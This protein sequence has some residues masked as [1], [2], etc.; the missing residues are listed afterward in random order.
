MAGF[1]IG[2]NKPPEDAKKG[3]RRPRKRVKVRIDM[4]PMV[5][6]AFL[7]LIFYMVT[8]VFS[9]PTI[10]EMSL[11]PK[12][13]DN[14]PIKV[15]ESRLLMLFV[16]KNDFFYYQIGKDMEQP[17]KV[18][19]EKLAEIIKRKN[20]IIDNL[21]M[22]LKVDQN[23]SYTSMVKII[24]QIQ[25]AERDINSQIAIARKSDPNIILE[26]YSARFSLQ[27]MSAWDENLL[28]L[29]AKGEKPIL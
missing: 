26:N 20:I 2:G 4:T 22:L 13:N 1:D 5:D 12:N 14:E 6:I 7:L 21:V 29:A 3:L 27:D 15:P 10:M 11:P 18:D 16:D 23:A 24:D 19:F 9:R 17:L 8:T 28:D 25:S